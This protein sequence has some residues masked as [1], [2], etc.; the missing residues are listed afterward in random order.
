MMPADEF[1]LA[2][3]YTHILEVEAIKNRYE[4]KLDCFIYGIEFY[5]ICADL[6]LQCAQGQLL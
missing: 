5:W 4:L 3:R 2:L 1:K 6:M